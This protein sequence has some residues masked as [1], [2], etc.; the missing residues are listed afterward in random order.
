[1]TCTISEFAA[2]KFNL[3]DSDNRE[4]LMKVFK[5]SSAAKLKLNVSTVFS[6]RTGLSY[7]R[8][9]FIRH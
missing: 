7:S 2:R 1:M 4:F 3:I 9:D 5:Q 8:F 6:Q